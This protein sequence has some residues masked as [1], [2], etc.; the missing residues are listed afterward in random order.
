MRHT[1]FPIEE[2]ST[3]TAQWLWRNQRRVMMFMTRRQ[4]ECARWIFIGQCPTIRVASNRHIYILT[5][6]VYYIVLA[7]TISFAHIFHMSKL[8]HPDFVL[9][10]AQSRVRR[11]KQMRAVFGARS[12]SIASCRG[13]ASRERNSS[14]DRHVW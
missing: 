4:K 13:Q 1:S 6:T 8:H 5:K 11:V 3:G 7:H 2:T 12:S 9:V 14:T 10:Y